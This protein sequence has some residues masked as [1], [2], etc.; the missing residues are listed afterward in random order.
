MD[1]ESASEV[2]KSQKGEEGRGVSM[3]PGVQG[4][5]RRRGAVHPLGERWREKPAEVRPC[6]LSSPGCPPGTAGR[7]QCGPSLWL[8]GGCPDGPRLPGHIRDQ[9][10]L[11]SVATLFPGIMGGLGLGGC[12]CQGCS[13]GRPPDSISPRPHSPQAIRRVR[14]ECSRERQMWSAHGSRAGAL[15]VQSCPRPCGGSVRGAGRG[16]A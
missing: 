15:F 13:E 5:P 14:T 1:A 9:S 8:G 7:E 4:R 16:T 3:R 6:F 10:S 11:W 2:G 12:I